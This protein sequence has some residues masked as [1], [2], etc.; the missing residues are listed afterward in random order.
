[1]LHSATFSGL[2]SCW[3]SK[4]VEQSKDRIAKGKG[5]KTVEHEKDLTTLKLSSELSN[6]IHDTQGMVGLTSL[7]KVDVADVSG[8]TLQTVN[9]A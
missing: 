5:K 2:N 1:M 3:S 6:K 7:E 9:L 8:P 4:V